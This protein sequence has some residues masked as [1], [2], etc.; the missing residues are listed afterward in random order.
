MK[1]ESWHTTEDKSRFKLVRTD[2]YTDIPGEIVLA[3]E[4]TGECCVIVAGE[5][6]TLRFGPRGIRIVGRGR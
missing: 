3:D 4:A 6:K 5:T 1:L 2:D